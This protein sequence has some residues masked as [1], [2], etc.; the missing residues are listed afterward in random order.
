[1]KRK[2]MVSGSGW[3]SPPTRSTGPVMSSASRSSRTVSR[4]SGSMTATRRGVNARE[5]GPR[6]RVCAGGSRL[7]I[8]GCG[9]W[10][11]SSRIRVASGT[12]CTSGSCA[13]AAENR[14]GWVNTYST[15]AK[16]ETT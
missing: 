13:G 8:E 14:S 1:M 6:S 5:A 10:P 16:R 15:S 7:T 2:I 11:P 3:V 4:M 12:T 9:L